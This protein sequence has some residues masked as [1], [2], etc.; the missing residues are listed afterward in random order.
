MSD[1]WWSRMRD[2]AMMEDEAEVDRA[3]RIESV[4]EE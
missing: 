3:E 1:S 4:G 2:E